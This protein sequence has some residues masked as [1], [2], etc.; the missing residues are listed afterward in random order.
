MSGGYF[1]RVGDS[2]TCGGKIL[3]GDLTFQWYG[4]STA[5]EG[6]MVTCG[7]HPGTYKILGGAADTFDGDQFLAGSL[8]SF[9]SCP[10]HAKFIPTI[11]DSYSKEDEGIIE[12]VFSAVE[13][14]RSTIDDLWVSFILPKT[15][16]YAG[17]NYRLTM[18]DGSVHKGVF[19][20]NNKIYLPSVSAT[21]CVSVEI[22]NLGKNDEGMAES[23]T[24]QL[25]KDIMG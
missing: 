16:N 12:K 24:G 22:E 17:L 6:D 3:T 9:S 8:D 20:V 18:D 13:E 4:V 10:C 1:L 23:M 25:L 11:Q 21:F 14:T 15:E 2:T 19:D 7:K 5:R